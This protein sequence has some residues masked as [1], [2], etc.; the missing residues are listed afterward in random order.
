MP[1]SAQTFIVKCCVVKISITRKRNEITYS[2]SIWKNI[3]LNNFL[4]L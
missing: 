3:I 4:T 1:R 2:N